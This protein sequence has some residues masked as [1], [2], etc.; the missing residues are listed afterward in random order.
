[1]TAVAVTERCRHRPERPAARHCP[2]CRRDGV[3]DHVTAAGVRLPRRVVADAVDAV[4][5]DRPA[6][7]RS[8]AAALTAFPTALSLGAPPTVGRLVAELVA[9]GGVLAVPGCAVCGRTDQPLNV[10]ETGGMC[11]RC[12]H[13]SNAAPCTRCGAT[14]PV[15]YSTEDGRPVCERC[16]RHERGHRRCGLCGNSASIAVR[17]HDGEPDVCVNCYRLPQAVCSRCGRRRP[18]NFAE[19][20]EPVCKP[21]A[22][23]ATD[24]CSRCRRDRPPSVRWPEGPLCDTCYT[25]ALRRRDRC[26]GCRNLRRLV[27]PPGPDANTCADCACLPPSHTCADCGIE[28]KLYERDRC[29]ACSLRRRTTVLLRGDSDE[30][31]AQF[32]G[33]YTA[34][35]STTTPRSALNWLRKGAGA[36][37]L[38]EVAAG[39]LALTHE[40]L[41][42]HPR[43]Q[44]ADYLR[45]V[46]VANGALPP[47]DEGVARTQRWATDLIATLA[48]PQDRRLAKAYT[49]WRV[50]RRLRRGAAHRPRPRTYTAA[51]HVR[52]RAAVDF[53]AWLNGQNLAL[54]DCRQSDVDLWLETGPSASSVRDFLLWATEHKHCR[55]LHVAPPPRNNGAATEPEQRWAQITRLLHDQTIDLTD[56]VAGCMLLLYGQQLSR[57]AAMTTDQI[58]DHDGTVVV[59]F[60]RDEI[61]LPDQLDTAVLELASTRRPYTG[62][63]SPASRWLLPGGLPGKPISASHLGHRLRKLGIGAL[64]GRRATMTHL[65]AHLPAAVLADLLNVS[66]GTAVRWMHEVGADWTRYAAEL[67]QDDDPQP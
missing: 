16:R 1:V 66:P 44:A 22:P 7:L 48:R 34:I 14:K 58:T 60:G 19:T 40:A 9:R 10:T 50:L 54:A 2:G 15:A 28:D 45:H 31:P 56:R 12:A 55:A 61:D 64:P 30:I 51:A 8:L 49:T 23:R 6:T 29:S 57:I 47:R 39:R 67:V 59:R 32:A 53:L 33:V 21:C 13:R 20:A 35:V 65:A 37:L 46:L 38:A 17:A 24:T 36:A 26:D 18:C 5:A 25:S 63:G 42:A 52:L 3:I 62:V 11:R 41:D 43:P 4:V 27:W